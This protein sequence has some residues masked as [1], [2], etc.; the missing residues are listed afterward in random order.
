MTYSMMGQWAVSL[1]V[2]CSHS[3]WTDLKISLAG[4]YLHFCSTKT[5]AIFIRHKGIFIIDME[6]WSDM[7]IGCWVSRCNFTKNKQG[8]IHCF[9]LQVWAPCRSTRMSRREND[10]FVTSAYFLWL[11]AN[12]SCI[13]SEPGLPNKYALQR[14]VSQESLTGVS[15]MPG[16]VQ[17][18]VQFQVNKLDLCYS[19]YC[20]MVAENEITAKD[21]LFQYFTYSEAYE[22]KTC[23]KSS[24]HIIVSH[25]VLMLPQQK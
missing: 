13:R 7:M 14:K 19:K 22:F 5:N 25:S 15:L 4:L 16:C 12:H 17:L 21:F 3:Q 2:M 1:A 6:F 8:L 20:I 10:K 24:V 9:H 11:V 18:Y 23:Y